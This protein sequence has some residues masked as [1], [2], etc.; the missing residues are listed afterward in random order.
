MSK[1]S[2]LEL[3]CA[4]ALLVIALGLIS[5]GIAYAIVMN[6]KT[7]GYVETEATVIGYA[8]VEEWDRDM[9]SPF[10]ETLYAE[11]VEYVVDG[12][13]YSA[14]NTEVSKLP[15]NKGSKI[16]IAYNPNNP[17]ECVFPHTTVTVPILMLAVGVI[18]GIVGAILLRFYVKLK[19]CNN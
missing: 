10:K 18:F 16:T 4:I 2:K 17:Q 5:G 1:G 3:I 19:N 13:T 11:I 12:Q 15:K 14:Q 6:N 9:G 8:E 7:K